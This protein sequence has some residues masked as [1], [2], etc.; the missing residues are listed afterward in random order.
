VLTSCPF[1]HAPLPEAA[2]R[3][4]LSCGRQLPSRDEDSAA[5]HTADLSTPLRPAGDKPPSSRTNLI[6]ALVAVVVI[7]GG[8]TG[9]YLLLHDKGHTTAGTSDEHQTAAHPSSQGSA[10]PLGSSTEQ[11]PPGSSA[12]QSQLTQFQAAIRGSVAARTLVKNAVSQVGACTMTPAAG[13]TRLEQAITDRKN[14]LAMMGGL[15]VSAIPAGQSMRAD[16]ENVLHLSISADRDFIGWMQ[17]PQSTQD[18]PTTT[19]Q[20]ASYSAGLTASSQA[21]QAKNQFLAV[22]NPLAEQFGLPTYTNLDI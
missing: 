22:W 8:G 5:P 21:M 9:A 10:S 14:V 18:C 6:L 20:D 1:C 3:F 12:E 7:A 2:V 11:S 16:L 13:A 15:S 4:C 19:T 17:D